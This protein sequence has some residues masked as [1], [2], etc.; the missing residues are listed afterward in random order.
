MLANSS[1]FTTKTMDIT[2][3]TRVIKID[4]DTMNKQPEQDGLFVLYEEDFNGADLHTIMVQPD[5]SSQG[6]WNLAQI[7]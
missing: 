1:D 6:S 2:V 5:Q 4:I 7:K 3:D